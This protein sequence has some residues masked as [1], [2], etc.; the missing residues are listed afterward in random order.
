M[1]SSFFIWGGGPGPEV[2]EALLSNAPLRAETGGRVNSLFHSPCQKDPLIPAILRQ[3]LQ[4]RKTY[5]WFQIHFAPPENFWNDDSLAKA[6]KQWFPMVL[7][8]C[9]ILSIHSI[10]SRECFPGPYK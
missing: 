8:W 5:E 2:V 7:K 6:N 10:G 9:K 1:F 4:R 3:S